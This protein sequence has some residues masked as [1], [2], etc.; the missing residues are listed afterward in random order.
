VRLP[1]RDQS[2]AVI[3]GTS[4]YKPNSG[5]RPLPTVEKNLQEVTDFLHTVTGLRH[6]HVV[7]NPADAAAIID[8]VRP[9]VQ[10]AEDLL[11]F[12]YAGHGVPLGTGDVGLTHT[13]SRADGPGWSTLHYAELR[14]EIRGTRAP[15]RMVILDSC[16][17]GRAFGSGAMATTDQNEALKELVEIEGAYVLTATNSTQKFADAA[18]ASGTTAFTGAL[19]DVMRTGAV[20]NERYLT[21]STVF[22]LLARKLRGSGNP[23][24]RSSGSNNVANIALAENPRWRARTLVAVDFDY[25]VG[26]ANRTS[27][28]SAPKIIAAVARHFADVELAIFVGRPDPQENTLAE[29]VGA[30]RLYTLIRSDRSQAKGVDVQMAVYVMGRLA[31]LSRLVLVTGDSDFTP[32]LTEAKD[33]GIPTVVV[34][35]PESTAKVLVQAA[36]EFFPLSQFAP[37]SH[38]RAVVSLKDVAAEATL[39]QAHESML[40]EDSMLEERV[41]PRRYAPR[42]REREI[43]PVDL[44]VVAQARR[45]ADVRR[46][47]LDTTAY[48][49]EE[50]K[51]VRGDA[52]IALTKTR[53]ARQRNDREVIAVTSGDRLLIPAFQFGPGATPRVELQPLIATLFADGVDEWSVWSWLTSPSDLLSGGVPEE[54]V[55][56]DPE[57]VRRAAEQ[58]GASWEPN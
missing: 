22:P 36:D 34:S 3:V 35:A 15:I 49:L 17:S 48:T 31:D 44:E 58:Y 28:V 24:P 51:E 57:S 47:L 1:N 40:G 46:A 33:A 16:H 39:R 29:D 9:A 10:E 11:L 56:T 4:L 8:A 37:R 6:V 45:T 14:Q 7:E 38:Q 42:V 12:Y 30:D 55:G 53:L 18:G 5:F 23:E 21:M 27:V 19:L 43:P 54:V 13:Q 2:R 25:L 50:L 52:F 41:L 20:G 26:E 32:V